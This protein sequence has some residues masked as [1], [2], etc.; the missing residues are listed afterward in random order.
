VATT[1]GTLITYFDNTPTPVNAASITYRSGTDPTY[2]SYTMVP[3]NYEEQNSF[4]NTQAALSGDNNGLWDF[5]LKDQT[6]TSRTSETFCFRVIRNNGTRIRIGK[7]PM[8]STYALSDVIIQGNTTIR[9]NTT[10][11]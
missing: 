2:G 6:T 11:R 3:E 9:G 8:I 4:T 10:L 5:S 1:S 7:Y